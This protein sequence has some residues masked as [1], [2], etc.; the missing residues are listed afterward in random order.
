M[1]AEGFL[2]SDLAPAPRTLVD[3][4]EAT[5]AAHGDAPAIDDG[6][7]VLTYAR[8]AG[9]G[10]RGRGGP[11]P[12]RASDPATASGSGSR[13]GR[14]SCTRRSSRCSPPAPPTCR[15]TWTTPTSARRPCSGRP[16]VARVLTEGDLRRAAAHR[17]AAPP[18]AR[19]R[20]LDHLHLG[21]HGRPQGRRGH[22]PVGRRVRRRRGPPVPPGGA[23]RPG[24]PGAGRAVGGV[25]RELRGDVARLG[26]RRLPGP[27]AAR[28][29]AHRHGPRA[30]AGRAGH[31]RHLDRADARGAVARRGAGRRPAAHLRRRGVP[32]RARRAAGGGRARGLE[33]VRA[34][35]GDRRRVRGAADRRRAR[36]DRARARRLGPR[37]RGTR[38]V[39]G[40]G[41]RPGRADHRRRRPRAVP[42][43]GQGR[44][45]VRARRRRSAGSGRT[46]AATSCGTS[47][48]GWCSSGGPTTRSRWAAGASSWARSTPRC[49][50]LPGVAGAAAAVRRTPAGTSV[51]VGY[52]VP[53]PGVELDLADARH[54]LTGSLPAALVPLLAPVDV[55]PDPRVREGRPRRAA[56]AARASRRGVRARRRSDAD[57]GV[58]GGAVD[59]GAR[60]SPWP[61]RATT[62]SRPA[63]GA[64]SRRSW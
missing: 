8:A 47:P 27:G 12:V 18:D 63:A 55:H 51:L 11:A 14:P 6:S 34:H 35:G 52:L 57:G 36:A 62:S 5:A 24:R 7:T 32:A 53:E 30:V 23:A 39:A 37:G 42:R 10:P 50:A 43:P 13:R 49:S 20:R 38:R 28:A 58:G 22:A 26:A 9:G 54:R 2:R 60:A 44:R 15:W 4:L 46:A 41:G 21:L 64:W 48:R 45:E 59:R 25:R 17:G 56:V 16:G 61:V 40:R 29:G 33:H 3:V 1:A 31:H 19:R